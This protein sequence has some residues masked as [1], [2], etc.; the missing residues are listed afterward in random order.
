MDKKPHR[1]RIWYIIRVSF[2]CLNLS[3]LTIQSAFPQGREFLRLRTTPE[4][5]PATETT[6]ELFGVATS[7]E[8]YVAPGDKIEIYVWQNPDLTRDVTIREDGKLSYP[9][10]GTF[11]VAGLSI[12]QLQ[13]EVRKRFSKYIRA[14]EVTISVKE[15]AG[16][17]IIVLGQ[18][19]Y[20]GIYTFQGTIDVVTAITKAGD[21]T[22]DGRRESIM[23]ISDNFT[24]NPKVRKFNALSALRNGMATPDAFLNPNDVVYVPR[25]TIADWNK[26][27]N[28]I[29]PTITTLTNIF[30]LGT[31][32]G[33][34]GREAKAWFWHRDVKVVRNTG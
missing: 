14:P 7:A 27:L 3:L 28:E 4:G 20:P 30:S 1:K 16:N 21:F 9:L 12:D 5:T 2:F 22:S 15:A 19:N 25:S 10:I 11:K 29:T 23:I 26:F 33:A 18:V 17:K 8:Y 34:T 32:A 31:T 24:P 6:P 13:E